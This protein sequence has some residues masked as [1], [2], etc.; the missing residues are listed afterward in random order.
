MSIGT[1]ID[2]NTGLPTGN[3][4]SLVT[5]G[6]T[7]RSVNFCTTMGDCGLAML[8]FGCFC[9]STII[10]GVM[11]TESSLF[12]LVD[13]ED[14]SAGFKLGSFLTLFRWYASVLL[15]SESAMF[16]IN[17]AIASNLESQN[18]YSPA[19]EVGICLFS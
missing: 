7:G 9:A 19:S 4:W 1:V 18:M 5:I 16:S 2:A 3:V 12:F 8:E 11:S 14:G 6:D 10:S 13:F 15:C 17:S